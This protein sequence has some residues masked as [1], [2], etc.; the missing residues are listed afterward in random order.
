VYP[1]DYPALLAMMLEVFERIIGQNWW[2][3]YTEF[4]QVLNLAIMSRVSKD[5]VTLLSGYEPI[6]PLLCTAGK[7]TEGSCL[8]ELRNQ[9][10]GAPQFPR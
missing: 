9:F 1:E 4:G 7:F 6:I 2:M 5:M 3:T 10:R 8:V